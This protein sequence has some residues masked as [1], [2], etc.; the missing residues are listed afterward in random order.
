MPFRSPVTAATKDC[1]RYK[2]TSPSSEPDPPSS[3]TPLYRDSA[4]VKTD[5]SYKLGKDFMA[6]VRTPRA[7]A[8]FKSPLTTVAASGSRNGRR[9]VNASPNVQALQLRLQT[10]KRALKIRDDREGE[11]LEG[12]A[13]KW[14]DVAREVAWEVWSVVKDNV[15]DVTKLGSGRGALQCNWGWADEGNE[16]G[17]TG[18]DRPSGDVEMVSDEDEPPVPE[19]TMSVMLRK[20]GIDPS[21]LGWNEAEGE[22]MEAD[23]SP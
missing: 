6:Q 20:M 3:P 1:P 9:P 21:T 19:D 12:L 2:D 14:T 11:K 16:S 17:T 8:Q 15:Q 4:I 5:P 13:Q 7:S 10:L 23:V 18:A 22:F